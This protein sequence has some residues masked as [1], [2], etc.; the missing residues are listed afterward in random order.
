MPDPIQLV[1]GKTDQDVAAELKRKLIEVYQPLLQLADEAN[2]SGMA[3]QVTI[4]PNA[5]GKF[6]IQQCQIMKV[7]K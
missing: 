7:F 5:F 3:F 6:T 2:D 1:P 4:G